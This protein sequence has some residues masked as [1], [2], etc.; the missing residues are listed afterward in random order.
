VES[1]TV[2]LDLAAAQVHCSPPLTPCASTSTALNLVYPL[3]L[4]CVRH[5]FSY[6]I[7]TSR[8]DLSVGATPPSPCRSRAPPTP[9]PATVEASC[10]PAPGR[11]RGRWS[12]PGSRKCARSRPWS[13]MPPPT[14][15]TPSGRL[16]ARP[17]AV[18]PARC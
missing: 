17:I 4:P 11:T 3:H 15:A 9:S 5:A 2:G 7:S 8:R 13:A 18:V 6:D 10:R 1:G 14:R 16:H 12:C